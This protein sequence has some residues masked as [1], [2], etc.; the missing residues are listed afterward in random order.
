MTNPWDPIERQSFQHCCAGASKLLWQRR[1]R[2]LG[3]V[4]RKNDGRIA[5]DILYHELI[6]GHRPVG[7]I[8]L[9]FKEVCK[10]VLKRLRKLGTASRRSQMLVP[11]CSWRRHEGRAKAKRTVVDKKRMNEA[12]TAMSDLLS[13]FLLHLSHHA[14]IGLLSHLQKLIA[15]G[16][17]VTKTRAL[18]L[19]RDKWILTISWRIS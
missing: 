2:W 5:K 17:G 14:R 9:R 10:G 16:Q 6:T 12:E 18:P 1:L 15:K 19:S 3:C 7:Y 11:C 13:T 4:Y 8:T